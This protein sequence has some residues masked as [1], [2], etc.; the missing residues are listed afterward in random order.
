MFLLR[1]L[2]HMELKQ[3][4]GRYF[5]YAIG[6]IVLVVVGILIALQINNWN[7]GRK[8]D[9]Q[10][11]ELIENLKRDFQTTLTRLEEP[12]N[13]AELNVQ[14]IL[15]L[16]KVAAGEKK[17]LTVDETKSLM[18]R[19]FQ[20]IFFR[21]AMGS[22]IAAQN[23]G[24]IT[25]VGDDLLNELFVEF[26]EDYARFMDV[27]KV[28]LENTFMGSRGALRTKLGSEYYLTDTPNRYRPEVFALSDQEYLEFIS[29]KE[30]FAIINSFY[31]LRS[32]QA[33]WLRKIKENTE[34]IL[35]ALKA[36]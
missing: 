27:E 1:Y 19:C 31:I 2:R 30:V 32:D 22:Y 6:E 7:E 36:L 12:L 15:D 21:P 29:Q 13:R 10:R 35:A 4:T 25:L 18:R 14:S 11:L 26:E 16:M 23:A 8:Q 20:G 17:D 5:L 28:S 3:R 33:R 9:Q 34:N 24:T